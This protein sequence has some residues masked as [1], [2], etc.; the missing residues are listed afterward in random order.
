[1]PENSPSA[2]QSERALIEIAT[3]SWRLSRLFARIVSKLDAGEGGRHVN[4]LRYFQKRL[5]ESLEGAGLKLVNVE[6]HPFDSGMAAEA[7][8]AADFSPDEKL[9]VDQMIE[10]IIMGRDGL[11]KQGTVLLRRAAL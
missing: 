1:M 6:G 8:N 5:E 9:L 3:E 4:Q 11:K 2:E 10:P 7:I